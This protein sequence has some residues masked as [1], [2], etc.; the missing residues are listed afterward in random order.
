MMTSID[1]PATM[2]GGGPDI[3]FD[4]TSL[5]VRWSNLA[6]ESGLSPVPIMRATLSNDAQGVWYVVATRADEPLQSLSIDIEIID[7]SLR[8]TGDLNG[9]V[10]VGQD[11]LNILLTNWGQ[12]V[13]QGDWSQGDPNGDGFLGQDDLGDVLGPWGRGIPPGAGNFN[14]VPEPQSLLLVIAAIGLLL[15]F[16]W[17]RK[18]KPILW[19]T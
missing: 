7:G 12:N 11:D 17:N 6:D 10:F 4:S 1:G 8:L 19:P 13:A 18:A 2:F 3:S 9:D 14:P 16:R 15:L 5:D